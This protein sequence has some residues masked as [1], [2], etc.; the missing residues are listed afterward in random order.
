[1]KFKINRDHFV[2]G[3]QRLQNIVGARTSMPILSNVLIQSSDDATLTLTTTNLDI[4][5]RLNVKAQIEEAG[6]IAL[7]VKK[8]F[9]IVKSLPNIEVEIEVSPEFQTKITSGGALFRI[10]G[11]PTND[12]PPLPVVSEEQSLTVPQGSFLRMLK[13]VAYAQSTDENRYVLNGVYFSCKEK[14]LTLVATDGKRLGLITQDL[15][16]EV[17]QEFHFVLPSKTTLE[18]ERILG[19]N[20]EVT[21]H[22]AGRQVSFDLQVSEEDT[23]GLV[24]KI[25][26]IS[27][28]LEG[29]YPNY[30]QVIPKDISHRVKLDRELL[31]DSLTRVSLVASEKNNAIRLKLEDNRLEIF[32]SSPELGES[33]ESIAIA[34]D[35]PK[36][37]L[38]FNPQF[39]MD[40]LRAIPKDEIYFEF[41]DELSPGMFKTLEKF[42][43]V[44]MPLR[45]G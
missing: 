13:S 8:L 1:M 42:L 23:S 33:R 45:I 35:G 43:C 9:T 25:L 36:I 32:G 20:G 6:A 24:G 11:M 39:L 16:E 27:K 21:I 7:P 29:N 37:E 34:H 15:E 30:T 10:M 44:V 3:L 31:L 40:P 17:P 22:P 19:Q 5:I 14:E 26:V 12:F 2:A 41:K 38:A 18:L 4:G 28:L